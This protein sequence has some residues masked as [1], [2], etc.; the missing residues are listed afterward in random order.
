M[1]RELISL[2][3]KPDRV[4]KYGQTV[5]KLQDFLFAEKNWEI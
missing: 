5:A 4:E 1:M 2:E 3:N